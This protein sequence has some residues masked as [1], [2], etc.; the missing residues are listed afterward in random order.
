[1]AAGKLSR[2][3]KR[4]LR[5]HC[6]LFRGAEAS[7]KAATAKPEAVKPKLGRLFWKMGA[8]SGQ[9]EDKVLDNTT[10]LETGQKIWQSHGCK[11]VTPKGRI[12]SIQII[13]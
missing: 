1:M 2:A 13:A 4:A 5:A 11:L 6:Q 7:C 8:S 10:T 3:H 12:I 9:F